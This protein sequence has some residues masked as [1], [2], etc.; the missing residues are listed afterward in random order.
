MNKNGC[1]VVGTDFSLPSQTALY[2]GSVLASAQKAKLLIVYSHSNKRSADI[3]FDG[4]HPDRDSIMQMLKSMQ[5]LSNDVDFEHHILESE[6]P[7]ERLAQFA[8]DKNA[9]MIIVG[10]RGHG[11]N[12]EIPVGQF[13]TDLLACSKCPV[14]ISTCDVIAAKEIRDHMTQSSIN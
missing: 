14:T 7:A 9:E 4:F 11:G 1:I 13:A 10:S 3:G 5:P 12:V 2:F 6:K 8:T